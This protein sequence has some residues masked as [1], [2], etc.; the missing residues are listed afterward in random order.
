MR[1]A[2][3]PSSEK[4]FNEKEGERAASHPSSQMTGFPKPKH[5]IQQL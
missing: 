1:A 2:A 5:Q 3:L 4:L